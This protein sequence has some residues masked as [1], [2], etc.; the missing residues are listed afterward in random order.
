VGLVT[1]ASKVDDKSFNQSAWE[2]V[3]RAQKELG[4]T[5][6]FIESADPKDYNK[7]I[8][9]FANDK[10]DV[11]VTVGFALAE[12]TRAAAAQFPAV[13]FIGVDQVQTPGDG[14]PNVVG[15]IFPEDQAGFMVG[16]L[17]AMMSKSG[18][19]GAVL[20][21]DAVPPVWRFGEGYRAGARHAKPDIE[22]HVVY[23]SDVGFEM[24]F[25]DPE[26]GKTTAISMIDK[27]VDVI[28]GAGGK[29]GNG[30]LLGAAAMNVYAIGVDTDQYY[31][32]PEA[33]K[34]LLSSAMKLIKD[35]AFDL[36]KLDRE[37]KLPSGNFLGKVGYAPLHDVDA[38]VPADVKA[39]ME[40]I[41]RDVLGGAI[42]IDVP[43]TKPGQ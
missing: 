39:K 12:A 17:A 5:V 33:Q 31:T 20:A 23:H 2:G 21:T 32:M 18:K 37:G 14:K 25:T 36:I 11:I 15:L 19:I 22:L 8:S 10:Y 6:Q 28:F 1:S 24:T 34:V 7:N 41:Q 3:Q 26:W 43:P 35:G 4:A 40:A 38:K 42:K 13:K 27:G 30:A 29:T 9:T 16:A